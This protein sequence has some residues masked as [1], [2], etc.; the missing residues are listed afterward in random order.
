VRKTD[1]TQIVNEHVMPPN[2]MVGPNVKG[3]I[4][5]KLT[6]VGTCIVGAV[7]LC[8]SWGAYMASIAYGGPMPEELV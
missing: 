1:S 7:R 2:P 4:R 5:S 8:L 6:N 3:V